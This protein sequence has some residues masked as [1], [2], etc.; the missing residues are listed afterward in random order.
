MFRD[1]MEFELADL[2]LNDKWT[3]SIK[4]VEEFTTVGIHG[5]KTRFSFSENED[6][7]RKFKSNNR[8]I[9]NKI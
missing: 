8:D 4:K 6:H 5:L 2:P 9:E 1:R 7:Q 3:R